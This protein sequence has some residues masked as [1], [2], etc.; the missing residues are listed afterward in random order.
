MVQANRDVSIL[1]QQFITAT[2]GVGGRLRVMEHDVP[3]SMGWR[4]QP[5]R[6]RKRIR[7]RE[8]SDAGKGESVVAIQLRSLPVF[9]FDECRPFMGAGRF[10]RIDA[11]GNLVGFDFIE[12]KGG[13][14]P[15]HRPLGRFTFHPI[16]KCAPSGFTQRS[17]LLFFC[18]NLSRQLGE[19]LIGCGV[20]KQERRHGR[21]INKAGV[22]ILPGL[23]DVLEKRKERI[24]IP[25]G[26]RIKLVIVTAGAFQRQTQERRAEGIDA[27]HHI[28]DP[29][30]FFDDATF[31]VLQV[32]AVERGG[33]TLLLRCFRQQ[34]AG[35]LPGREPVEGQVLV[36][37][38]NDPIA[39]RPH[40]PGRVHLISIRVRVTREVEP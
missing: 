39:V 4:L 32:E 1:Q 17:E 26:N 36:E 2:P 12:R 34:I 33:Q 10:G 5:K 28:T 7:P 8:M 18:E 37:R 25:H 9:A 14:K 30:L 15:R 24:E 38:L 13:R 22:R 29:E 31:L 35:K 6:D 27:I 23:I 11:V 20:G 19:F 3:G 16:R 21:V 40:R